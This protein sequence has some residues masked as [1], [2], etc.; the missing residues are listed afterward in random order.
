MDNN[1]S[2][3]FGEAQIIEILIGTAAGCLVMIPLIYFAIKRKKKQINEKIISA[4]MLSIQDSVANHQEGSTKLATPGPEAP[5]GTGPD[6]TTP[7]NY[8]RLGSN[9]RNDS[10]DGDAEE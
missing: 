2:D 10:A 8:T 3:G 6:D 5:T 7:G 9:A 4:G 1:G